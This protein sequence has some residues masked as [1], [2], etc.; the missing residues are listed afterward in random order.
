MY[1]SSHLLNI[2]LTMHRLLISSSDLLERLIAL[3]P[4][5]AMTAITTQPRD[6]N[7]ALAD[8]EHRHGM[9]SMALLCAAFLWLSTATGNQACTWLTMQPV[10]VSA[11]CDRQVAVRVYSCCQLLWNLF[12]LCLCKFPPLWAPAHSITGGLLPSC[13]WSLSKCL[14]LSLSFSPLHT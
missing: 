1:G 3:Y 2:S 11:K 13:I 7:R 4:S 9:R 8:F 10:A 5:K 14:I 6:S 12:H